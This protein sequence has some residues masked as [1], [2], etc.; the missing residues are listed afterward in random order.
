MVRITSKYS[1]QLIFSRRIYE[2][3]RSKK[4]SQS[5]EF[6]DTRLFKNFSQLLD[7]EK[8][9]EFEWINKETNAKVKLTPFKDETS[10]VS[11]RQ[12]NNPNNTTT[13]SFESS[14]TMDLAQLNISRPSTL[15]S[16]P[17]NNPQTRRSKVGTTQ[18]LKK[19]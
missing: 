12:I 17:K 6:L 4:K 15:P 8:V 19:K 10:E 11:S 14:D 16:S 1:R 3:V 13:A 18:Q 2:T 5:F 9:T 7:K